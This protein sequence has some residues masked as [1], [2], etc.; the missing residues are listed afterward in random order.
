MKAICNVHK[1]ILMSLKGIVDKDNFFDNKVDNVRKM[2]TEERDD[3]LMMEFQ[4]IQWEL[5][6]PTKYIKSLLQEE[7]NNET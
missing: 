1:T 3:I 7:L 4:K 5:H 6:T 2:N